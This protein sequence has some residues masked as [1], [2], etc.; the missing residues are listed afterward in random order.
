ME[1]IENSLKV[2]RDFPELHLKSKLA[3]CCVNTKITYFLR[4][5]YPEVGVDTLEDLDVAF[6]EFYAHTLEFPESYL[7]PDRCDDSEAYRRALK[8]IRF[9]IRDGGLG[10][11]SANFIAPAALYATMLDF[12]IWWDQNEELKARTSG[13][14]AASNI[15]R[16]L[17]G[18]EQCVSIQRADEFVDPPL[19][20]SPLQLPTADGVLHW[21][22]QK[23]P[24]QRTITRAL[25]PCV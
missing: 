4:A 25:N 9:D 8:Q 11:T 5:K 12:V 6:E 1:K 19:A 20:D 15:T 23:L 10:L 16:A 3:Q 24:S 18:M 21:P 7:E 14:Y 22:V 17:D 2:L 13:N